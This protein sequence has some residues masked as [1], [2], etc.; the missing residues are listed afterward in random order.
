MNLFEDTDQTFKKTFI[1]TSNEEILTVT[2]AGQLLG[3][4]KDQMKLYVD[5]KGLTKIKVARSVF[6]YL[7]LKEEIDNLLK[8][9]NK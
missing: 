7:L 8:A 2:E 3:L 6:R 1:A 4:T 5:K 9:D